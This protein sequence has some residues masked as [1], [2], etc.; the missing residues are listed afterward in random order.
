MSSPSL[1]IPSTSAAVATSE[2][3]LAA[4]VELLREEKELDRRRDAL[5]ARRR[6]L[7]RRRL[8][9]DYRFVSD[10]G[11]VRLAELFA[12]KSQLIVYHFMFA[13]G[14]GEGCCACSYVADHF[15]GTLPHLAAREVAFAAVSRAP[16][17]EILPYKRRMGWRFEWISSH[18]TT[19]NF[20]F[21]VSFSEEALVR[22]EVDYNYGR[23]AVPQEEMPGL[24]VF[25]RDPDGSVLHAYSTYGRGLDR[26]INTYNLLDLVP[27]GRNENPDTT[28]DWVRRHDDY[29][30]TVAAS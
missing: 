28:M 15:D 18:G 14:W 13:P 4:R 6:A 26:I 3:W 30:G 19:F 2:D 16:I 22:G 10:R 21:H 20:D 8:D 25:T 24:S 12:G 5:S 23:R 9:H 7:P 17:E 1:A 27:A 11:T 29:A